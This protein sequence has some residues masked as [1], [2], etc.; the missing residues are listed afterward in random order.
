MTMRRWCLLLMVLGCLSIA[1]PAQ[2]QAICEGVTGSGRCNSA[3]TISA[4]MPTT[5]TDGTPFNDFA[6]N[7][8]VFGPNAGVCATVVGTTIKSLG[9][10]NVPV[11]P[12][13]NTRAS[14]PLGP[15]GLPS[16]KVFAAWRVVDLTGNRSACSPEVSFVF[17]NVSPGPPTGVQ[18]GP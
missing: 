6:T 15:I 4:L 9:T 1:W 10:L 12:L 13:P 5:N 16:G 3:N 17:D 7:E 14:T 2:A 18:V 11:T 8:L